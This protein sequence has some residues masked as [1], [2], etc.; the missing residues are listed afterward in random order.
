[1]NVNNRWGFIA[2]ECPNMQ[3][4]SGVILRIGSTNEKPHYNVTSDDI[5]WAHTENDSCVLL[6]VLI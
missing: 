1:M 5:G 6:M 3:M 4:Y 2:E